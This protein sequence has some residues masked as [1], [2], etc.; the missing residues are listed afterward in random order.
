MAATARAAFTLKGARTFIR[1]I[2]LPQIRESV[3]QGGRSTPL[4]RTNY[5][6]SLFPLKVAEQ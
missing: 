5:F 2:K 6:L 1:P 4:R 3:P